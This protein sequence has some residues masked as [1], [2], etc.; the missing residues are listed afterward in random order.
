[1]AKI[2]RTPDG[3]NECL[4][5]LTIRGLRK[6]F[7]KFGL[8]PIGL[9]MAAAFLAGAAFVTYRRLRHVIEQNSSAYRRLAFHAAH[10]G[11]WQESRR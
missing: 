8:G 2:D 10:L 3:L 5:A 9:L 4:H 11:G 6:S 1:M 7:R